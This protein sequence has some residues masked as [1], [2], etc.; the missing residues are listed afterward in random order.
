MSGKILQHTDVTHSRQANNII[1]TEYFTRSY[2]FTFSKLTYALYSN[3]AA[4]DKHI[5]IIRL[6]YITLLMY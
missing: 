2:Y 6:K 4:K 3:S 1:R 5:I